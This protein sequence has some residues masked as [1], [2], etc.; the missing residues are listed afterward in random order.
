MHKQSWMYL[1]GL[2]RLLRQL[3]LCVRPVNPPSQL[4]VV[5]S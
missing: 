5:T 4:V 3:L 2:Q 1:H